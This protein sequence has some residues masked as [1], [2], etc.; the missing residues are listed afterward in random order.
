MYFT[1]KEI[2]KIIGT[3]MKKSTPIELGVYAT[4]GNPI[5]FLIPT[6]E[7][8]H[9]CVHQTVPCSSRCFTE[10]HAEG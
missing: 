7:E 9:E 3:I 2:A 1:R 4:A 10:W 5:L 8:M 6:N